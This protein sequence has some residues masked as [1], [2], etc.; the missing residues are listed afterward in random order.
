VLE[1][2]DFGFEDGEVDVAE[3]VHFCFDDGFVDAR[4]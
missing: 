2:V 4:R 1:M 3:L